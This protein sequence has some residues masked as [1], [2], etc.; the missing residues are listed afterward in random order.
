MEP[1]IDVRGLTAG[2]DEAVE[3]AMSGLTLVD[4]RL[5]SVGAELGV[6]PLAS[7]RAAFLSGAER[8]KAA[9]AKTPQTEGELDTFLK[10][11]QTCSRLMALKEGE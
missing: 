10:A 11:V 5:A 1:T 6:D 9:L 2:L 7:I 4:P 8:V 3:R